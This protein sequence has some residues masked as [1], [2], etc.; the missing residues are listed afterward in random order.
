MKQSRRIEST[1]FAVKTAANG[2]PIIV[3][4]HDKGKRLFAALIVLC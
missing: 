3:D 1:Q 2:K 4:T